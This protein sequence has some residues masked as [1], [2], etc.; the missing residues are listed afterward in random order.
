LT[1]GGQVKQFDAVVVGAG[2]S[3]LYLLY[4]LRE[5]GLSTRLYEAGGGG[6]TWY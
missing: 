2:L 3:G 4:R 6:G 1:H 5:L